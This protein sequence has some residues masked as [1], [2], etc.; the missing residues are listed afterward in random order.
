MR[1]APS[2]RVR[3]SVGVEAPLAWACESGHD[4]VQGA[5]FLLG[6]LRALEQAAQVAHHARPA[7]AIAQKAVFFE[8]LFEM[9][10]EIEELLLGCRPA[11]ASAQ[12]FGWPGRTR[13][14]PLVADD[15]HRLG[16]VQGGE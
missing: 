4:T 2:P 15:Q 8:L 5:Q 11:P 13:R 16:E 10:E 14:E 9:V 6:A 12:G 3:G 1:V 7:F